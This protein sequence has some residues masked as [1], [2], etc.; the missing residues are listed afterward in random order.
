M[1]ASPIIREISVKFTQFSTALMIYFKIRIECMGFH[2]YCTE[3]I[4]YI[5]CI[6][7]DKALAWDNYMYLG[8]VMFISTVLQ[9]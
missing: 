7:S 1:C 6:Y 2:F 3:K 5:I 8:W 9:K 4:G